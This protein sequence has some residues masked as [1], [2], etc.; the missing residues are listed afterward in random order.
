[1]LIW[2]I[3][4][5]YSLSKGI[6][7]LVSKLQSRGTDVYLVSGGFRQMI[8]VVLHFLIC[9]KC[10]EFCGSLLFTIQDS[11]FRIDAKDTV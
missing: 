3:P 6:R 4:V 9:L 8:A 2:I 11:W 1:M 10:M 5:L 7:E